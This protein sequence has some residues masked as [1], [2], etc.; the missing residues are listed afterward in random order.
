MV[1]KKQKPIKVIHNKLGRERA[2]GFVEDGSNIINLDSRLQ[3]YRYVLYLLHE[4]LHVIEP[5]WS[6]TRVRKESS[7]LA[8]LLWENNI[9][10]VDL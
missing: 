5:T 10:W 9:R 4:A 2:W 6:E 1:A 7:R 3:G 8:K